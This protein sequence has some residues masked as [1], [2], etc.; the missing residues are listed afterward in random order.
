MIEYG[1]FTIAAIQDEA[2]VVIQ[3]TWRGYRFRQLFKEQKQL[4]ILHMKRRKETKLKLDGT[5][6]LN[7]GQIK[8]G[9]LKDKSFS[10]EKFPE[11]FNTSFD[12]LDNNVTEDLSS[13]RAQNDS[14]YSQTDTNS[15]SFHS[16]L[17]YNVTHDIDHNRVNDK[18]DADLI[19]R[20]DFGQPQK[21]NDREKYDNDRYFSRGISSDSYGGNKEPIKKSQS[22]VVPSEPQPFHERNMNKDKIEQ[23]QSYSHRLTE[24]MYDKISYTNDLSIEIC[25]DNSRLSRGETCETNRKQDSVGMESERFI[26]ENDFMNPRRARNRTIHAIEKDEEVERVEKKRSVSLNENL[27]VI[28]RTTKLFNEMPTPSSSSSSLHGSTADTDLKPWQIYKR[29]RY[30]KQL[31]RRKIESAIIIQ[32][33]FKSHLSKQRSSSS[34]YD[35]E[36]GTQ[37]RGKQGDVVEMK[38]EN[39][40]EQTMQEIAALLIQLHWRRHTKKKL[41]KQ[42]QP[43]SR[44]SDLSDSR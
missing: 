4:L 9:S 23:G 16:Y 44:N 35:V 22:A 31:I 19:L 17:S 43:E 38:N 15:L 10:D 36:N 27:N 7:S 20:R 41:I 14:T 21:D 8:D 18:E 42:Q 6:H 12:Q 33:A 34:N 1:A 5:G 11:L 2:A 39:K 3:K 25:H 13:N 26:V 30:R 24:E 37:S 28:E 40:D 29:D 32:R